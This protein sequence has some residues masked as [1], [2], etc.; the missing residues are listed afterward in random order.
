MAVVFPGDQM[1]MPC[2]QGVRAH[3]GSDL[4]EHPPPEELCL[5]GQANALIIGE[6][7]PAGAALLAEHAIL[8]LEIVD[9]VALLLVDPARPG[10]LRAKQNFSP[11]NA[12]GSHQGIEV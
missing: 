4:L 11:P 6:A 2:E 1:P 5:G 9:H 3:N 8:G 7:Q 10:G 12:S